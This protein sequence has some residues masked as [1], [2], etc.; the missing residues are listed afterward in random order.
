MDAVQR[1]GLLGQ[2]LLTDDANAG[3]VIL[4]Y[5]PQQKVFIDDR[6]DMYPR[7]VISAFFSLEDGGSGWAHTLAHYDVNVVVWERSKP[8]S[9]YLAHDSHW[10]RT[11]RDKDYVVY[12][13]NGT[14]PS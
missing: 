11:Y 4:A 3:Y 13:K 2:R 9:Q 6:Y 12:V 1:Q 10:H 14:Q 8:L 5:Y 7:S